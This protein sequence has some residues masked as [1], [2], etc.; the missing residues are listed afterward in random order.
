MDDRHLCGGIASQ[1]EDGQFLVSVTDSGI[2]FPQ[3]N[4]ERIFE[5]FFTTKPQGTG[6]GL[7]ISRRI[8]ESECATS[9]ASST[10]GS[11]SICWK[12][13]ELHRITAPVSRDREIGTVS[14][15]VLERKGPALLF[16]SIRGYENAR[17]RRVFTGGVGTRERLALALGF[18]VATGPV[19]ENIVKGDAIDLLDPNAEMALPGG[20]Q[21]TLSARP[22]RE[23]AYNTSARLRDGRRD[24][25]SSRSRCR[26]RL[27]PSAA[28]C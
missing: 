28:G 20:L 24:P 25:I 5:A 9:Q 11:G 21:L 14:R 23:P 1:H 19:K 7:S 2:G 12:E 27:T 26:T 6:M 10:C 16:E 4:L 15:K 18:R 13:G 17:G 22:M 3:E 8:I